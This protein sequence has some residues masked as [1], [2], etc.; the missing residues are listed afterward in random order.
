MVLIH[1]TSC[2]AVKRVPQNEYLLTHNTV[3]INDKKDNSEAISNLIYQ[4]PNRA[5]LGL[6]LR[7]HLYNLARPN[8]DSIIQVKIY[9]NKD[10]MTWKTK[11]LSRKQLEKDIATR[12][13]FNSWLK[14]T[15][16]APVILDEEK[17]KKSLIRLQN[18]H[19]NNG[20]F[21][22]ETTYN[23]IKTDDKRAKIEY[24]VET[25]PAFIIDSIS[26]KIESPLVELLY[27]ATQKDALIKS[28]E[29]Y[30]TVNFEQERDRISTELRNRGLYRFGQEHVSFEIDTVGTNKKVNVGVLISNRIVT[31]PDTTI[32]KPFKIFKVDKVNIYTD[33]TFATRDL[34]YENEI[35]YNGYQLYSHDK[36]RYRPKAITDAVFIA[37]KTIFRDIDRTRSYRYLNE[38]RT[39]KYPE[40][41]YIAETDSTLIANVYLTPLKKFSL[42]FSAEVSQSNIQSVGLALNPSLQIRNIFK[43]AETF[44][45]SAI[46][47]IGASKDK[48]NIDD[49]FFDI[50]E[51]GIDL[52]LRIPRLFSPF[53]TDKI[54]PKYMS[55]STRISLSTTS[56]TNVGLDK[57]TFSGS[58]NYNWSP[59]NKITNNLDLFNVQYVRNLNVENYF[60]V[61]ESSYNSLNNIAKDVNYIPQDNDLGIPVDTDIF[62]DYALASPTPNEINSAQLSTIN[63][64]NERKNRLTENNLIFSTS[65]GLT[66][67]VRTNLFDEDFSIFRFRVEFAGN[68]LSNT[69][70]LLG[71]E[72]DEDNRYKIFN[73]AFSQ[74]AKTEFD[75]IK[76]WDL[77]KKNVLAMR[78]Y[79]GIAIPYGNSNNI[80]F[81]KSFFAGGANDNRAWTA[82]SLGPGSS[83][84]RNEFNE[85]NLKLALGM[86]QRFNLFEDLNAAIFVD[87]GNIWNVLDDVEDERATFTSLKSLKDIAVGSG[88]GLRYDFSF[89]VFRFDIG[90]KTYDPSYQEANRWF[91]D[92]NFRNAVYNIGI[93]YPF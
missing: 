71:L 76:H 46:T 81:S 38:L 7:L 64:I 34:P 65:F 3:I 18:Y 32:V 93:N 41:K 37:P 27:E 90:F 12:K 45:I 68:L 61:Y 2:D 8:I 1:L 35:T 39:F 31:N 36:M 13:G 42:G 86:E 57:Q 9:D 84:T 11:L 88:F 58:F 47:S 74:Y 85:A 56:Q 15:G 80:P 63:S 78:S 16:E 73:V 75:Y 4:K 59:S 49:P 24:N 50:N 83:E 66:R 26:K 20:W 62:L 54:V 70:K 92:Y 79:F 87:A 48:N 69:S 29:Q 23:L 17:T 25:G 51:F 60:R 19:I 53:N 77:G 43:G 28:A 89:F 55:P 30:R 72:K 40:I 6:P 67:D 82:Y 21:D 22:A 10:K 91:N 33:D 14:R 44:E 52:G 5:I